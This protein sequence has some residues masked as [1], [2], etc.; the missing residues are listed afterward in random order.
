MEGSSGHVD[1]SYQLH[2]CRPLLIEVVRHLE[3]SALSGFREFN[4]NQHYIHFNL[5]Q[6]KQIKNPKITQFISLPMM[7]L[8]TNVMS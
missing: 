6:T 8:L 1:N 2:Q 7:H 3:L 5:M 4:P